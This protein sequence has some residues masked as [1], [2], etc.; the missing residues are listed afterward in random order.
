M[1]T[2]ESNVKDFRKGQDV[3]QRGW[4]HTG[5]HHTPGPS[6]FHKA[7]E[8]HFQTTVLALEHFTRIATPKHFLV[9]T[10]NSQVPNSSSAGTG[11]SYCYLPLVIL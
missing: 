1:M 7:K 5:A 8:Q 2:S 9:T 6:N 4:V 3:T 10:E 11:G